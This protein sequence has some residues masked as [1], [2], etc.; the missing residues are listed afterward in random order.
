MVYAMGAMKGYIS[1]VK[2]VRFAV[3]GKVDSL[4][5]VKVDQMV[6]SLVYY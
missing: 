4:V 1:V 2:W 5:A 3:V 6:L